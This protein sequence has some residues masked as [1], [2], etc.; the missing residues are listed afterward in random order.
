MAVGHGQDSLFGLKQGRN[1]GVKASDPEAFTPPKW[2]CGLDDLVYDG[3]RRMLKDDGAMDAHHHDH[4]DKEQDHVH[5]KPGLEGVESVA[6]CL[7]ANLR[8]RDSR[9]QC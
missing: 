8:G 7:K 1:G 3:D 4:G 5:F 9:R 6:K 2:S